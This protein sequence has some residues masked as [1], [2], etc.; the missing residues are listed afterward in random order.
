MTDEPSQGDLSAEQNNFVP[1]EESPSLVRTQTEEKKVEHTDTQMTEIS[2]PQKFERNSK[3]VVKSTTKIVGVKVIEQGGNEKENRPLANTTSDIL[4]GEKSKEPAT[5]EIAAPLQ[6]TTSTNIQCKSKTETREHVSQE[7]KTSK[8]S[9]KIEPPS[10]PP[11]RSPT[12]S[13]RQLPAN[14]RGQQTTKEKSTIKTSHT[15]Q[16]VTVTKEQRT[17]AAKPLSELR[18][19]SNATTQS[20][21]AAP[22]STKTRVA[23]PVPQSPG[24]A[25]GRSQVPSSDTSGYPESFSNRKSRDSRELTETALQQLG[26]LTFY[27]DIYIVYMYM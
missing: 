17:P 23:P 22:K 18:S 14:P 20:V 2:V 3:V 11:P 26:K 9:D 12:A 21:T 13:H 24:S 6:G 27:W 25:S 16:E 8:L 5:R 19:N 1:K 10:C 15:S 7:K 4:K